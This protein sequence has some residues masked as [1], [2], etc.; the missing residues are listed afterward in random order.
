MNKESGAAQRLVYQVFVALH[1]AENATGLNSGQ[2]DL[3]PTAREHLDEG[4]F[5]LAVTS[6]TQRTPQLRMQEIE[7]TFK[8][9]EAITLERA[10]Q[11]EHDAQARIDQQRREQHHQ[12][13][14]RSREI[15]RQ[16]E[17]KLKVC[18]LVSR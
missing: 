7:A 14:E 4:L 17:E 10:A 8:M 12:M 2:I 11:R 9:R 15:K 6:R 18:C 3:R 1:S 5:H 16:Y 13:L